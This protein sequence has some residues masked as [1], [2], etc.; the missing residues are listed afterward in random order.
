MSH[1]LG[2]HCAAGLGRTKT[3]PESKS[4][5]RARGCGIVAMRLIGW[6]TVISAIHDWWTLGALVLLVVAELCL[7]KPKPK[8]KRRR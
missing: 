7:K 6:A 1:P 2:G 4:S 3:I 5:Q 8:A